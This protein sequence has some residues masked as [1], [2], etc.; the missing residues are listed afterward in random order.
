[1]KDQGS[2]QIIINERELEVLIITSIHTLKRGKKKCGR[3]DVYNLIRESLDYEISKD[4][5]HKTLNSLIESKSVVV[6]TRKNQE[7]LSMPKDFLTSGNENENEENY[8]NEDFNNFKENFR[9]E[10]N[11]FKRSF[12]NEVKTFKEDVLKMH[13]TTPKI[14]DN[15]EQQMITLLHNDIIFLKQQLQQ[16]DKF[17]DSL[18]KQLSVQNEFILQQKCSVI[19]KETYKQ[20]PL[21]HETE[22]RTENSCEKSITPLKSSSIERSVISPNTTITEPFV[23]GEAENRDSVDNEKIDERESIVHHEKETDSGKNSAH[24]PANKSKSSRKSVVILGDS[25]AK[26]L[27][28]YEMAKKTNTNCKIYIK[29]ISGATTADMEDYMKPS[30]RK[31]PTCPPINH[32]WKL[33]MK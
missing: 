10:F 29:S 3:E 5:Y 26:S 24:D 17:I 23:Q 4:D 14:T 31:S 30:V 13:K 20:Q 6:N 9:E 12:F 27:N 28:G 25:M 2:Q 22:N 11:D 32:H 19:Q 16:K 33:P 21:Q 8:V 18:I 1:M 15:Q 7:C